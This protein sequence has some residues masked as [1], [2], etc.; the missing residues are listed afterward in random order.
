MQF[1]S[2]LPDV[3]VRRVSAVAAVKDPLYA[4]AERQVGRNEF[5]MHVAGVGS[6]FVRDGRE[7]EY[8]TAPGADP[9]W[10]DLYLKMQVMVV[11][12]HQRG[13]ISF[14]A[15]SFIH[16]GRGIMILGES[17][18][19]KSSLTASFVLDGASFLTDDLTPVVFR[20]EEPHVLPLYSSIR[21]REHSVGELEIGT[22]ELSRAEAGSGKHYMRVAKAGRESYALSTVVKIEIGGDSAPVFCSPEPAE[23]FSLLRSEVCFWEVLRGMPETEAAYLHQ[24]LEIVKKVDV[25]RVVRPQ[26]IRIKELKEAI[27]NYLGQDKK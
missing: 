4:D 22:D 19:G 13:I 18:A 21:L 25:V 3:R 12:L 1:K 24:L 26:D 11:L 10:I 23:S 6:F 14:H 7:V 17:G 5:V 2:V 15:S 27:S 20:R 9:D 8:E 16:D